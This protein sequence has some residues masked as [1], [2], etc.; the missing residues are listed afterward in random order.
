[1]IYNLLLQGNLCFFIITIYSICK[2]SNVSDRI[3][4]IRFDLRDVSLL[5]ILYG[6]TWIIALLYLYDQTILFAYIFTIFNSFHGLLILIYYCLLQK[7][8]RILFEKSDFYKKHHIKFFEHF[9]LPDNTSSSG[10]SSGHSS[11]VNNKQILCN[12]KI[13]LNCNYTNN[14]SNQ[15]LF[16]DHFERKNCLNNNETLYLP[17]MP[18]SLLTNRLNTF[19]Y[20]LPSN[21]IILSHEQ[22]EQLLEK[23]Q[24]HDDEHQYYEIR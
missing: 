15:I 2:K 24:I 4:K 10:Y 3:N 17:S 1:M 11:D 7:H 19:R 12:Q 18:I 22:N 8:I 21:E 14:I 5:S 9:S 6:L 20:P 23:N 16:H 13:D